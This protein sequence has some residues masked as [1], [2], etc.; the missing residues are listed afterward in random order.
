MSK[1]EL[2]SVLKDVFNL[3]EAE[4]YAG[5]VTDHIGLSPEEVRALVE[6][7]A[8]ATIVGKYCY[9]CGD[10]FDDDGAL[11]SIVLGPIGDDKS[12]AMAHQGCFDK[13]V[14]DNPQ[15]KELMGRPWSAYSDQEKALWQSVFSL[16]DSESFYGKIFAPIKK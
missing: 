2:E 4:G 14:K 6:E 10:Q 13:R 9:I 15:V 12:C 8:L 16:I 3:P 11:K 5:Q 7:L 1:P